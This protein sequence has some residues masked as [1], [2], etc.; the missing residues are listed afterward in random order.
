MIYLLQLISIFILNKSEHLSST[1]IHLPAINSIMPNSTANLPVFLII[2]DSHCKHFESMI[3]TTDFRITTKAV[4]GL[5]WRNHYDHNLCVHSLILSQ[6]ISSLISTAVSILFLVGTNS[7]RTTPALK[8]IEQVEE[9][10][11]LIRSNHTHLQRKHTITI[12]TTFPCY[13]TSTRFSSTAALLLNINLFNELLLS[14]SNRL[15]F[16]CLDLHIDQQHL[17]YDMMH[18]KHQ[19][20]HIIYDSI[21]NHFQTVVRTKSYGPQSQ[22]RS[23]AAITKRNKNVII[24]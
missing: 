7:I 10:V 17:H 16:S 1:S 4:S 15:N 2:S 23:R 8:I 5:Q 20:Q 11:N 19:Y 21:I 12:T 13:K 24:D 22:Q 18:I 9:I 3:D 14:S 6:P